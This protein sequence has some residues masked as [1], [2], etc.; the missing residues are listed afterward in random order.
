MAR[1]AH[2]RHPAPRPPRRR[3]AVAGRP[4]VRRVAGA[5]QAA[6]R[7]RPGPRPAADRAQ[8]RAARPGPGGTARSSRRSPRSTPDEPIQ[9][10]RDFTPAGVPAT[11]LVDS[12]S[13]APKK[14]VP[15]G[16][17]GGGA[18][19]WFVL[20][21]A[22]GAP[23][24]RLALLGTAVVAGVTVIPATTSAYAEH[25][26][27]QL[28]DHRRGR[29]ELLGRE[30]PRPGGRG[31]GRPTASRPRAASARSTW[32]SGPVTRTPRDTVV[33]DVKNLP[34][35][36]DR[37]RPTRCATPLPGPDFMAVVDATKGSPDY[38]KVVNTATV[39][40]LVE[41]EPH[42]MQYSWR[43]GDKIYAGGLYSAAT[44]VFDVSRAAGAQ[45][46]R[47]SACRRR[48]SAVRCRTPTGCSRTA[49]PTARTWAARSCP[50]PCKLL[51]TARCA[52]ATASPARPVRSS[53]SVTR[54][55]RTWS[56]PRPRP[57]HPRIRQQCL[58]MPALGQPTCANPHGIQ[59]R[60]DLNTM[61]TSDYAEPRDD[62]PR[63]GQEPVAVPATTDRA[64]VGH[65][66]P[67]PPEGQVGV[68]PARPGPR[69]GPEDPLRNENRAVMET[70]VTNQPGHKGAFAQTMQGGAIYYTPDITV[71]D[72]QWKEVFDLSTSAPEFG[73]R[74]DE[75][76]P[77]RQR[78]MA[79]DQPGRQDA[80]PRHDRP[81][82]RHAGPGRQGHGG[83]RH[84]AR[85]REAGRT[86]AT[87]RT[88]RSTPRRRSPHGGAD[89]D[90]PTIRSTHGDQPGQDRV[91]VRTGARWTTSAKGDDGF[92]HRD[93]PAVAAGDRELLRG[94]HRPRR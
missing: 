68:L 5:A 9:Q 29:Q 71:P 3:A 93:R 35:S 65:Q 72:P 85:H 49:P 67:Q 18:G 83:W 44:Y 73:P 26:Q 89:A 1:I 60:E 70:T 23:V 8:R 43:K 76:W 92:F 41:N 91:P 52:P 69:S 58:N 64:H 36:V 59:V 86:P 4:R 66:R 21:S 17:G 34:G 79:A 19:E 13:D 94:P 28:R 90:C 22:L 45:A 54:T 16:G 48:R 42:H 38:G 14:I 87:T 20:G 11:G 6:T 61:V 27:D 82:G 77:E 74:R 10:L 81:Q 78:R 2:D 50:D 15:S 46:L 53:G 62:H 40:P 33:P 84:R 57:R 56:R 55:A 30:Q 32:S 31:S 88:A 25:R 7:P 12:V 75:R 37:H 80:L 39:G 47:R 24:A 63:P 51:A